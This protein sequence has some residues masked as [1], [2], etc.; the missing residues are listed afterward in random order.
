MA[1]RRKRTAWMRRRQRRRIVTSVIAVGAVVALA[2]AFIPWNFLADRGG[3]RDRADPSTYFLGHRQGLRESDEALRGDLSAAIHSWEEPTTQAADPSYEFF[4]GLRNNSAARTFVVADIIVVP[5]I[6]TGPGIRLTKP[7]FV[8]ARVAP[9]ETREAEVKT[10]P[11]PDPSR[12]TPETFGPS[13]FGLRYFVVV[14]DAAEV[15]GNVSE[16]DTPSDR[17]AF[18]RVWGR[19]YLLEDFLEV[20]PD[21]LFIRVLRPP[22]T[23]G[24]P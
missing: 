21:T 18:R 15:R 13:D 1:K 20:P 19:F 4:I 9:G 10:L 2:L 12:P 23:P 14:A 8:T 24:A 16:F 17:Q 11:V 22:G 7:G 5:E 3:D 6:G